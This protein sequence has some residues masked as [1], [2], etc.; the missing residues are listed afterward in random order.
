MFLRLLRPCVRI[1]VNIP[2]WCSPIHLIVEFSENQ[3]SV[4]QILFLLNKYVLLGKCIQIQYNFVF[5][6]QMQIYSHYIN[7]T[8]VPTKSIMGVLTFAYLSSLFVNTSTSTA[9]IAFNTLQQQS[10]PYQITI[11]VLVCC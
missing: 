2:P 9:Y 11:Q 5:S 7:H 3:S 10:D 1:L 8:T 6:Y 4:E